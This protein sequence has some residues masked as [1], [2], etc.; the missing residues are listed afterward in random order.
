MQSNENNK[1]RGTHG[2]SLCMLGG[3]PSSNKNP[4]ALA[5]GSVKTDCSSCAYAKTLKSGVQ[6]IVVGEITIRQTGNNN[7]V[8][9]CK[10]IKSMTFT[11][12]GMVCSSSKP[13]SNEMK[14]ETK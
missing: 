14:G 3:V 12:C 9:Q 8:C 7:T 5:V 6:T 10:Q 4:P 1:N 11:D 2:D 13:K